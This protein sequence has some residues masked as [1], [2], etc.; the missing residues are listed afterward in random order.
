MAL[1][2]TQING[3]NWFEVNG[4]ADDVRA[5]LAYLDRHENK[6]EYR[7]CLNRVSDSGI[8]KWIEGVAAGTRPFG[9]GMVGFVIDIKDDADAALIKL[10][11][12]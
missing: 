12:C 4:N 5:I 2:L 7:S 6:F 10:G 1:I 8:K 3:G 11:Y 9:L